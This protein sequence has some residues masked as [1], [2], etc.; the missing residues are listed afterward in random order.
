MPQQHATDVHTG[1]LE[2]LPWDSGGKPG[3]SRTNHERSLPRQF[4]GCLIGRHPARRL[5]LEEEIQFACLFKLQS[6]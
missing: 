4:L 6:N 5:L 2:Q 1:H 3:M